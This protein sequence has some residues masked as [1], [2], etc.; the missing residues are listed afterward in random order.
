MTD[1]ASKPRARATLTSVHILL[2]Y[3]CN[4]SCDHCFLF[5]GP[6]ARGTFTVTMLISML[7]DIKK[8]GIANVCFEGGEAF[9]YYPLLVEGIRY[10]HE[11]GLKTS[12]VTNAY[13]AR[14]IADA[15]LWLKPLASLSVGK[16]SVS[17]DAFHFGDE[18]ENSAK[19]ALAAAKA[20][21]IPTSTLRTEKP[22]IQSVDGK[23]TVGGTT[24]FKGRAVEK[25]IDG[26]PRRPWEE[27]VTCPHEKLAEPSRV[28]LDAYGNVHLCQGVCMGNALKTPLSAL[29]DN[30][31]AED[32]PI[33]GLLLDGGP[34]ALARKYNLPHEASYVDECHFCYMLRRALIETYPDIL[35]PRQ[36]YGI[37]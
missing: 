27:L 1:D 33:C 3:A 35:A 17:A 14:S 26:L 2:T 7:D 11:L 29:I 32:D 12:V 15:E 30:Y 21:G 31:H 22:A 20:L 23:R 16:I 10:A 8:S 18:V 25:F 24:L 34:A 28:H 37:T 6:E 5:S 19:R 13:W 9:L 36:V 4:F